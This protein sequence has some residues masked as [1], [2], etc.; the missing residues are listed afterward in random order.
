MSHHTS[1]SWIV[2]YK[3]DDCFLVSSDLLPQTTPLMSINWIKFIFCTLLAVTAIYHIITDTT[4]ESKQQMHNS[5]TVYK[6][7]S[8][9]SALN[10]IINHYLSLWEDNS[11]VTDISENEWM[12]ISLL[13]N[14]QELYKSDQIKVYLLSTKNCKVINEAFDK[15]H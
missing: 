10:K 8:A 12:K 3:A 15:L 11:N 14:W 2:K 9:A 4:V 1:L 7:T 5:V 6:C 13:E